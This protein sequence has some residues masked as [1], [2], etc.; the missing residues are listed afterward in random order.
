MNEH[1]TPD[2]ARDA[3]RS[4]D[5]APT[6][7]KAGTAWALGL[8]AV[9]WTPSFLG[10]AWMS[11]NGG[12]DLGWWL[13]GLIATLVLITAALILVA[14][15]RRVARGWRRAPLVGL[16]IAGLCYAA[17]TV[18]VTQQQP[19]WWIVIV[20]AIASIVVAYVIAYALVEAPDHLGT[21]R[22]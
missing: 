21:G 12:L 7:P 22:R 3:L 4:I 14:R 19:E 15:Q 9:S 13:A 1:P 11:R 16:G 17:S 18:F 10:N 6:P 20:M 8:A 5:T 2:A